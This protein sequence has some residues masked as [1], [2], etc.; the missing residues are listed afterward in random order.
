MP[1]S[2][3]VAPPPMSAELMA[4]MDEAA[5][6]LAERSVQEA[7]SDP[8]RRLEHLLH[9]SEELR[10]SWLTMESRLVEWIA[11]L[12]PHARTDEARSDLPQRRGDLES[13][14]ELSMN[15]IYPRPPF[16]Q[17]QPNGRWYERGGSCW[18]I[19]KRGSS[20][21]SR[22]FVHPQGSI[23]RPHPCCSGPCWRL[24]CVWCPWTPTSRPSASR[25]H[26]GARC[27][28]G[29]LPPPPLRSSLAQTWAHLRPS[30]DLPIAEVGSREDRSDALRPNRHRRPARRIRR[31]TAHH[32]CH[33]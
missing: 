15:S 28:D 22:R 26:S 33:R 18:S 10:A 20:G 29:V 21:S 31:P 13:I 6:V 24:G 27:G 30:V 8:D 9:A 19:S 23:C 17:N 7:T 12:L 16:P 11:S 3:N 4:R 2:P 14:R 1:G 5:L 32:G 25:D